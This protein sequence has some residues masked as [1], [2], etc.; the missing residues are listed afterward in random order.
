MMTMPAT[1]PR[2]S[3]VKFVAILALAIPLA[4]CFA[5]Q[6]EIVTARD[7]ARPASSDRRALVAN[8]TRASS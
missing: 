5:T 6:T 8:P 3:I 7:S 4:A 1:H 2:V